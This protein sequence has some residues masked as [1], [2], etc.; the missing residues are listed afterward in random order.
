MILLRKK[1]LCFQLDLLNQEL[2]KEKKRSK[3]Y[4]DKAIHAHER[5]ALVHQALTK[6]VLNEN[7]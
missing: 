3:A 5:S 6:T 4:K 7:E 2:M 1:F